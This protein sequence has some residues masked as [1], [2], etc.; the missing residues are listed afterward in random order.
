MIQEAAILQRRKVRMLRMFLNMKQTKLLKN[1]LKLE[2][3][4]MGWKNH[5]MLL[6]PT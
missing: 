4:E 2:R 6:K 5:L 3:M 1:Q